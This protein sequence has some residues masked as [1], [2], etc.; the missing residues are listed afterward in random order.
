MEMPFSGGFLVHAKSQPAASLRAACGCQAPAPGAEGSCCQSKAVAADDARLA[1]PGTP[2]LPPS[3]GI[4][5]SCG[6]YT[7]SGTAEVLEAMSG[8]PGA[9]RCCVIWCV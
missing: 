4:A 1:Q 3:L 2:R 7:G 6:V 9:A 5:L 8:S